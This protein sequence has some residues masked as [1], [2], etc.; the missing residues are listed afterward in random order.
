ME[1]YLSEII[2]SFITLLYIISTFYLVKRC[3]KASV[4]P[5]IDRNND[6]DIFV[7]INMVKMINELYTVNRTVLADENIM[8]VSDLIE[9][10]DLYNLIDD[11]QRNEIKVVIL[12]LQNKL[13]ILNRF[14]KYRENIIED[15]LKRLDD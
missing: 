8:I 13:M 14:N 12:E 4:E 5:Q 15:L 10:K 1:N 3:S 11:V 6:E 9:D 2:Y 7:I